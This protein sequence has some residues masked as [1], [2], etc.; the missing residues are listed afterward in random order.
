MSNRIFLTL[1]FLGFMLIII[2]PPAL[3]LAVAY[4]F[5]GFPLRE[6]S[7]VAC[8]LGIPSVT[9]WVEIKKRRKC[10]V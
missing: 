10:H 7:F 8:M 1:L 3:L 2:G 6:T 4:F 9:C 5:P